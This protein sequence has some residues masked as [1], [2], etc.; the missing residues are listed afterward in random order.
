[1]SNDDKK[2]FMASP[3]YSIIPINDQMVITHQRSVLPSKNRNS[4]LFSVPTSLES[5]AYVCSLGYDL[6][7]TR[8]APSSQFDILPTSFERSQIMF[9]IVGL[10]IALYVV[11]PWV[12]TKKLKQKWF[13]KEK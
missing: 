7:C 5:T 3:Y 13:V 4:Q 1:M 2:E 8:I 10:V 9:T 12:E 6:F 11:K